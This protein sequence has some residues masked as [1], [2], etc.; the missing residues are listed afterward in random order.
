MIITKQ[1][2]WSD[3]D[4]IEYSFALTTVGSVII[5]AEFGLFAPQLAVSCP[6][7]NQRYINY[8]TTIKYPM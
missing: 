2:R 7:Y 8:M 6:V 1:K 3:T 4:M 5:T